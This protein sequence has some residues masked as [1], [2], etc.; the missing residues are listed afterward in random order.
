MNE[1]WSRGLVPKFDWFARPLRQEWNLDPLRTPLETLTNC[2]STLMFEFSPFYNSVFVLV[3][4]RTFALPGGRSY[5]PGR[6]TIAKK[7]FVPLDLDR[8]ESGTRMRGHFV[9]LGLSVVLG[10]PVLRTVHTLDRDQGVLGGA[11][12]SQ[13][14]LLKETFK[15]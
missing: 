7:T 6:T 1:P 5:L 12:C 14:G 4:S 3:R 13:F 2:G 9:P 8:A 15:G 10:L 11:P